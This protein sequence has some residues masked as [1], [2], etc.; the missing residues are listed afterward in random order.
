[1]EE[2]KKGESFQVVEPAF[3]PEKPAKPNRVAVMLVGA[4]LGIGLSV[5]V[6]ALKE[7]SDN[8]IYDSSTLEDV[9][10]FR[11]LSVIPLIVL[12]EDM[13]Q[14]RRRRFIVGLTGLCGVMCVLLAFHLFV[15]DFD[16]FF[17]KLGRLINRRM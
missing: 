17:A 5:G 10:G 11:I 1:M 13:V 9:S 6:A 12:P 2:D 8:R 15:M 3:Q 7:F 14:K 4:V 16:I